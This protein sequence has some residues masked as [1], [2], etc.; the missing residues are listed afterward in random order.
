MCKLIL[1]LLLLSS[2]AVTQ[3]NYKAGFEDES[4]Y[5]D[6]RFGVSSGAE[7]IFKNGLKTDA[8]YRLRVVDLDF[9]KNKEEHDFLF[10]INVPI[11]KKNE[12]I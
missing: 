6:A 8:S 3:V 11:W 9:Q 4:R 1:S 12:K 2:C 10:N 5:K 7:V